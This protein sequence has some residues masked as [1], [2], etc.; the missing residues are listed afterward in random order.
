M[1]S[2]PYTNT[3]APINPHRVLCVRDYATSFEILAAYEWIKAR[4]LDCGPSG[5]QAQRLA[6]LDAARD[7]LLVADGL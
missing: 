6:R 3:I 4:E 1:A 5:G 7:A 2:H